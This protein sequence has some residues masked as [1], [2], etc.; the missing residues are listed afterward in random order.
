MWGL[1]E[2]KTEKQRKST[3]KHGAGR[4]LGFLLPLLLCCMCFIQR[5]LIYNYTH[6]PWSRD[7]EL[8]LVLSDEC[9]LG[10]RITLTPGPSLLPNLYLIIPCKVKQL[11][12]SEYPEA[13]QLIVQAFFFVVFCRQSVGSKRLRDG[14]GMNF[15]LP[16]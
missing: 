9:L 12:V 4:T 3:C 5:G 10:S 8:G 15:W 16:A 11:P 14:R 13:C 1:T 2:E 6:C 7:R